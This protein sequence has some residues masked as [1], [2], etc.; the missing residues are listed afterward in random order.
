MQILDFPRVCA[1]PLPGQYRNISRVRPAD[2]KF[3]PLMMKTALEETVSQTMNSKAL[4]KKSRSWIYP[5]GKAVV[6]VVD[7]DHGDQE[8]S[9]Q[10]MQAGHHPALQSVP[11]GGKRSRTQTRPYWHR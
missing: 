3:M 6:T 4:L 2:M 8:E 9:E 5:L 1:N 7:S 11:L 10:M